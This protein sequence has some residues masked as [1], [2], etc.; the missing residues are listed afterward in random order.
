MS[1]RSLLRF[2]PVA[3]ALTM[4]LSLLAFCTPTDTPTPLPV[5]PEFIVPEASLQER[6]ARSLPLVGPMLQPEAEISGLAWYGDVL[7]LL[8]Q[9]PHKWDHSLFGLHKA[10]LA[11][12]IAGEIDQA[13]EPF[14]IPLHGSKA[15]RQLEGFEGL[16]AIA[17]VGD[18]VYLLSEA[19][20]PGG[21]MQGYLLVG[22]IRP[23]L[24]AVEMDMTHIVGLAT[25]SQFMNHSYEALLPTPAGIVSIF[26]VNGVQINADPHA[27]LHGPD[28]APHPAIAMPAVEYRLTDA[29]AMNEAGEFWMIN[30]HW[31]GSKRL[32]PEEDPI[33]THWGEGPS[34]S[35]SDIVERILKFRLTDIGVEW[36]NE[37]PLELQLLNAAVAR[38][39]EGIALWENTGFLVA[40]DRFPTTTLAYVPR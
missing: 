39:W 30:F 25:Q 16:E 6:V 38:N 14:P 35:Q 34:Q 37:A 29:T 17:F 24:T 13:L 22:T 8:P 33:A 19:S 21:Y 28:L 4:A 10:D 7:V 15:M 18:T 32:M 11:R 27:L 23:D 2:L 20:M 3:L 40:T 5:L 9:Y 12:A 1:S 31:P 36:I 26:E